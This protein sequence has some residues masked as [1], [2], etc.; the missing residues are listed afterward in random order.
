MCVSE[1]PRHLSS[2]GFEPYVRAL[3]SERQNDVTLSW[4]TNIA[5][6]VVDMTQAETKHTG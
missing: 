5:Q 4:H 6:P 3:T 1:R 2:D